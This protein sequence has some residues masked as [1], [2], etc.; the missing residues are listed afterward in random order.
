G[1]AAAHDLA[2]TSLEALRHALALTP[3]GVRSGLEGL[4]GIPAAAGAPGT[5]IGFGPFDRDGYKG[6]LIVYREI[7]DG[8]AVMHR[9]GRETRSSSARERFRA[10]RSAS[11]SPQ[12]VPAGSTA[13]RCA[14]AITRARVP[15]DSRTTTCGPCSRGRA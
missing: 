9:P 2:T 1:L 11:E 14:S 3:A 5:T 7:R 6:P 8:R 15:R 13:S 4:R 10:Q 12:R